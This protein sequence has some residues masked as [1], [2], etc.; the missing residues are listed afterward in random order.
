MNEILHK[1][2]KTHGDLKKYV[3]P[4]RV[5]EHPELDDYPFLN[6]KYHKD[7]QIIIVVCQC[8]NISGRFYLS[9]AVSS[10]GRFSASPWV[11]HIELARKIFR[12]LKN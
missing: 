7:F 1:Y 12:Y 6:E 11:G 2:Q 5:K 3:L 10:L 8:L 9:Y 4:M